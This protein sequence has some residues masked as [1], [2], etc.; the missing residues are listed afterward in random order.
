MLKVA[1]AQFAVSGSIDQN[2]RTILKQMKSASEQGADVI[3]FSEVCLGGYAGVD[4]PSHK[5]FDYDKLR[6]ATHSIM[7]TAKSLKLWVILGSTH[8]LSG[9]NKP[10]NSLYIINHQGKLL[11]R[12]DKM[13]C[14]GDAKGTRGD[15]KYYSPGNRLV[16]FK[17]KGVK[18]GVLICHDFRYPELYREYKKMGVQ[19]MF[20][21]YH[22]VKL[23]A[24]G[25]QGEKNVHYN[26][27]IA[28]MKA[29]ASSNAMFISANNSSKKES[30]WPSF[31]VNPD[32]FIPGK[33]KRNHAS[34]LISEVD[35]K[36]RYYDAS[37]VWRDRSLKGVF[38]SGKLIRDKRSE[39]TQC[40]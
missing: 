19:L 5:N 10:H 30:S 20:H 11:D 2:C 33:L 32:G 21:S 7:Q 38:H 23:N 26:T 3:H 25:H 31:F 39:Q 24:S 8:E 28:T 14:T 34:I 36:Q 13:F 15:L 16:C 12:Y 17:I 40:L 22:N 6:T 4:I 9:K 35:L 37:S 1:T 27:V 29:Y 18:C